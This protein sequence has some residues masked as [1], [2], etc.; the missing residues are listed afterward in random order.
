MVDPNIIFQDIQCP[1][2]RRQLVDLMEDLTQLCP[3]DACVNA[4]FGHIQDKFLATIKV[5]SEDV[6]MEVIDQAN[7]ISE[8]MDHVKTKLM[9]QILT[10]RSHRFAS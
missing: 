5:A 7:Q 9:G 10:W 6:F 8:V 4:T 2:L 3:S 1:K